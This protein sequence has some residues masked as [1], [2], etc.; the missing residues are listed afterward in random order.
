[1]PHCQVLDREVVN[2]V[3][4]TTTLLLHTGVASPAD[5]LMGAGHHLPPMLTR[6]PGGMFGRLLADPRPDLSGLQIWVLGFS[7]V[8]SAQPTGTW[9]KVRLS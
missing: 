5:A 7:V 6:L 1:M 2:L 4:Q 9:G 8:S 3:D